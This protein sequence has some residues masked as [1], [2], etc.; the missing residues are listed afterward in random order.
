M[1]GL[2]WSFTA[3]GVLHRPRIDADGQRVVVGSEIGTLCP[4]STGWRKGRASTS[5]TAPPFPIRDVKFCPAGTC[6]SRPGWGTSSDSTGNTAPSGRRTSSRR[7]ATFASSALLANDPTPT[8]RVEVL[9]QRGERPG[10][11][12]SQSAERNAS[13]RERDPERSTPG[14]AEPHRN[15]DGWEG[16]GT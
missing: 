10:A 7:H 2:A 16:G 8:S 13:A 12:I 3:D 1:G 11:A 15:P 9:G 6:S 5:A 4:V 14:V